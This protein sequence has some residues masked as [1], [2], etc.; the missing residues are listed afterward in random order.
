MAGEM[1]ACLPSHGTPPSGGGGGGPGR[2]ELTR[3]SGVADVQ[4]QCLRVAAAAFLMKRH[5]FR[6][7]ETVSAAFVLGGVDA[8]GEHLYEVSGVAVARYTG[9]FG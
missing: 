8:V 1:Q 3:D 9:A 5:L 2:R 7:R 6:Y 4:R